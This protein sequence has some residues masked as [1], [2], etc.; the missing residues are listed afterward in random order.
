MLHFRRLSHLPRLPLLTR[1]PLPHPE[2][3]LVLSEFA[4][5][6]GLILGGLHLEPLQLLLSDRLPEAPDLLH[7]VQR[8]D[9]RVRRHHLGSR[10]TKR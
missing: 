1:D 2:L 9:V 3:T 10:L 4:V 6:S 7:D 5:I 8:G